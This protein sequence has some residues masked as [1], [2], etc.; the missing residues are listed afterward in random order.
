VE[1][2]DC[3]VALFRSVCYSTKS[4]DKKTE[5]DTCAHCL[6][7]HFFP[8]DRARLTPAMTAPSAAERPG[9]LHAPPA[10]APAVVA[11]VPARVVR[12]RVRWV[13]LLH[14]HGHPARHARRVVGVHPRRPRRRR[15]KSQCKERTTGVRCL[16]LTW[17]PP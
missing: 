3:V 2:H 8:S 9:A 13:T 12:Y 15:K 4:P 14:R 6:H 1:E 7:A 5:L 16:R 10:A 11:H 17:H